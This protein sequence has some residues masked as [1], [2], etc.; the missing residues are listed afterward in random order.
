MGF[1]QT[2]TVHADASDPLVELIEGW[3]RDQ[4]GVAPGY[5]GARLLADE[6]GSRRFVIEVDFSS[7]EEARRNDSRPE[8]RAWAERLQALARGEPEYRD[9]AVAYATG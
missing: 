6:D 7:E 5:R 1:T 9:Y 4:H 8:T 3:H 2:M